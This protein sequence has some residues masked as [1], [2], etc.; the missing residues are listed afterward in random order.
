MAW[1]EDRIA[2]AA[3]RADPPEGAVQPCRQAAW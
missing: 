2:H 1:P 3:A